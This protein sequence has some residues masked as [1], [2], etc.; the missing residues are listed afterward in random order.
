MIEVK[1][2]FLSDGG[3]DRGLTSYIYQI[4]TTPNL[5][6][7]PIDFIRLKLTNPAP[8]EGFAGCLNPLH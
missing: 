8:N 7:R 3:R 1:E 6:L 5:K 2:A 4:V